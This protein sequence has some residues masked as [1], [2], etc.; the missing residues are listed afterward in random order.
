MDL[1]LRP[2]ILHAFTGVSA[3][4][5]ATPRQAGAG[6]QPTGPWGPPTPGCLG[7]QVGRQVLGAHVVDPKSDHG[8]LVGG[9][10][11]VAV[12]DV[13]R[14]SVIAEY[15]VAKNL[16]IELLAVWPFSDDV[17][18]NGAELE[19]DTFWGQALHAGD[20]FQ[21]SGRWSLGVDGR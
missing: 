16:S 21:L 17:E 20:D 7:G 18:L 3:T 4:R 8:S 12:G 9:A 19:L 2:S 1:P 6:H 5:P 11:T 15:F 10:L 14:P 13:I